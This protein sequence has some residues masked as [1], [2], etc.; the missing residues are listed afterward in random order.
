MAV[1]NEISVPNL[2]PEHL[3]E[4]ILHA[5]SDLI[6]YELAVVLGLDESGALR[7]RKAAGPLVTDRLAHHTIDLH[8]RRD[9]ARILDRG[10]PKLFAEDESH[11]DSYEGVLD[12]PHGHSCLLAPLSVGDRRLGLLTLD[13]RECGKFTPVI[14]RFIATIS[15]LISL[16]L[17]Q[18]D[19]AT[20]LEAENE[21]LVRERNALLAPGYQPIAGLIGAAD[22]WI[23]AVEALRLV[24]ATELPVLIL[25]ETGSGKELAARA[26]HRLS[27]RASGP[28]IALNCS[29]LAPSL[30]ESELFGHEKGS[31]TGAS[32]SKRGRFEL[33]DGG[34][35]FL[36]EIGDLPTELQPKLLRVL[37]EGSF[38]RVG[39]ERSLK[40]DVRVVAATHID[41]ARAVAEGRF[42]E[43]LYY[44]LSVFP[45]HL[46]PL[47]DRPGDAL[48]LAQHF[49][50]DI[51]E[52]PGF[53]SVCMD[54]DSAR[55]IE[56][57]SWPGNVRQ[58]RNA[59]ERAAILARGGMIRT[60]HLRSG[61]PAA[62]SGRPTMDRSSASARPV[63]DA[64][65]GAPRSLD[66]TQREAIRDA[67][68]RSEGRIYG[69][70]G[71]AELLGLKPTTLQSR[72]KKLG[73]TKR[74]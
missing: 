32:V 46:P 58:L 67:L 25:G 21:T 72:M 8:E 39:G 70:G 63:V 53:A 9:L 7:V 43:D 40:V 5:L 15:T 51:R 13:H 11:I 3:L 61:G 10:L 23:E 33:A 30:A 55:A 44:R 12:L 24:A 31:F 37:Q 71:A 52:R 6:D 45:L 60:E 38:E 48:L 22:S 56:E 28:W 66:D 14:V 54:E 50:A 47:R 41:L 34:T 18:I 49:L 65:P 64:L 16:S 36:D 42:R 19:Q 59:L 35:L 26:V 62:S 74:G 57:S 20:R 17:A 29:A 73:I 1:N 27:A 2:D 4:L 68:L 69:K